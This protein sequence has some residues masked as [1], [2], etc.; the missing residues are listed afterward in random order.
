MI[1]SK[2]ALFTRLGL[3]AALGGCVSSTLDV[4]DRGSKPIPQA[5]VA[6]M[7]RKSM[8]PASPVLMRIFKQESQLEIWKQD[9]TGNYALLKTY[10]ICRWSGKLGPKKRAG[11]RQ[12]PEGFYHVSASMLN[13]ESDDHLSVG[14]GDPNRLENARG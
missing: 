11:D 10:P 12:A 9:K 14:L 4:D 8:S 7:Q 13:P 1:L 2:F 6:E 5:L 3:L